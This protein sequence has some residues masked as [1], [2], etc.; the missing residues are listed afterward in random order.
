M[1]KDNKI[2]FFEEGTF[3]VV[4]WLRLPF[5]CKGHGLDPWLGYGH[6]PWGMAENKW[7]KFLKKVNVFMPVNTICTL[8][9]VNQGVILIFK[10]YF[11]PFVFF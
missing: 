9:P 11:F 3:L 6:M 2:N 8:H 4:Q 1:E 5:Q 10:S 7:I